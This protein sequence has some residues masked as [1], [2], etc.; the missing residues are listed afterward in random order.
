MKASQGGC[1]PSHAHGANAADHFSAWIFLLL[2][3]SNSWI[4]FKLCCQL[5]LDKR[6]F[7]KKH[8]CSPIH[9]K[10]PSG[11]IEIFIFKMYISSFAIWV[12]LHVYGKFEVGQLTYT[13]LK[14]TSLFQDKQRRKPRTQNP[15]LKVFCK[16]V[17]VPWTSQHLS[18]SDDSHEI[19]IRYNKSKNTRKDKQFGNWGF[20]KVF[21]MKNK[22]VSI[23]HSNV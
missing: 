1:E 16:P 10:S 19:I 13:T 11:P 15:I 21:E 7:N 18:C 22:M 2:S 23:I 20:G 3:F 12:I 6:Q 8:K 4:C 9:I 17:L 14:Q 5:G